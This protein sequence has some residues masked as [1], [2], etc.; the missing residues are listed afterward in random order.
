[1]SIRNLGETFDIHGGG[2]DLIFPHHE[3]EIAQSEAFTGKQFV[4]YWIHNGFITIDKEKM[5]KSLGNFFT[6]RE[7]LQKFPPEVLRVF[8]LST[9]YRSPIEFS[10]AVLAETEVLI[11][12]F[13]TTIMR[14]DEFLERR[15]DRERRTEGEERLREIVVGF[16][17]KFESAMDDD[18]NTALAIGHLYELIR[19]INRFLD[20]KP[21]GETARAL[22]EE[23]LLKM[24]EC[25]HVLNVFNKRP[26]EWYVSLMM[27]KRI[28]LTEA[29]IEGRIRARNEARALRDWKAA[30]VIRDELLG[31]DIVLEDRPDGTVWRIKVGK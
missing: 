20:G 21:L 15:G 11:D 18:F 3:N 29:D 2:A 27:T 8:L 26:S 23:A 1:M 17:A 25:S 9:H 16:I 12:R 7:V 24:R 14:I 30:D 10:D 31:H 4:K 19:E 13:Y 5:S 28:P 6:I 22:V